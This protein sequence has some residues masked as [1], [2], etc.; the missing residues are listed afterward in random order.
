MV[1]PL[2]LTLASIAQ[3]SGSDFVWGTSTAAYQVEGSR[4]AG[5]RQPSVWDAFDTPSVRSSSAVRASKPNG[6]SN[7]F[8]WETGA[9]ADDD[10][11]RFND[12]AA[13]AG[14]L[15][16]NGARLSISWSR[17][18]TFA[19]AS[20]A[21]PGQPPAWQ[22]N[23]AGIAHYRS[24]LRA[25]AS[26]GIGVALTMFHWDTPLA[27]EEAASRPGSGCYNRSAW[28]CPWVGEAFGAYAKLLVDEF[29][30]AEYGV[31]WWLTV[32]E[33]LTL[34]SNGYAAG[35][36]HAPGRCSDRT[37]CSEGDDMVEPYVVAKNL[38]LAHAHAF[39]AWRDAGSP[40]DSCGIVLNGDWREPFTGSAADAAAAQRSLEFEA[41]IFADPIWFG[42]WPASVDAAVGARV[43]AATGGKWS[44]SAAE[45][46]LVKGAHDGT[47][48]MNHYTAA[49]ARAGADAGCGW[50]CDPAVD[51][52]GRNFTSGAPIG[53][54]SSIGW[55]FNY[56]LGIR[57]LAGWYNRRYPGT[58][59]VVTESGWG[60]GTNTEAQKELDMHDMERCTYYRDYIGNISAAA[61]LDG[62]SVAGYF[63]WSLMDNYEWSHGYS[64]RFGITYVDY[65]TQTRTPKLSARWLAK[66]VTP[67]TSLPKDGLPLPPCE[68]V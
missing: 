46:Q 2:V 12:S 56:G 26:R 49:F 47:F 53:T 37:Q 58:T 22:R 48:F 32:N 52:S 34:M 40:G 1:L 65:P 30:G 5:G 51:V 13:L 44:W 18:A 66:H 43:N 23:E 8:Q 3:K 14:R 16:F 50:A 63:A 20:T 27:L 64:M 39:H 15:G 29:G 54:A 67:L 36:P 35:A 41:P 31:R 7:V 68:G 10:Y 9:V 62:V 55:L 45:A 61:A 4:S 25:Y 17:V 59:F 33:P 28:L 60:N 6:E 11:N 42:R 38:I 21:A 57:K 19:N 24:V